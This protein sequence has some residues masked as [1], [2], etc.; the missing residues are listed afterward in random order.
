MDI[1]H[2]GDIAP[3]LAKSGPHPTRILLADDDHLVA[4]GLA[5]AVRSL[6][7]EVVGPA[8]NG[9]MAVSLAR[10]EAGGVGVDLAVLDIRMPV[11][12]GVEAARRLWDEWSIPTVIASAYSDDD[13]ITQARD[14]GGVFGYLLKPI[15]AESLR[16]AISV[17]WSRSLAE[18]GQAGRIAQLEQNLR[19]RQV[20]ERAKWK[21]V[22]ALGLTEPEAH[23]RLQR[24]A[25]DH[26]R[27]LVEVAQQTIDAEDLSFLTNTAK[28]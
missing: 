9:A 26:R 15:T 2:R 19:N 5:S 18:R 24:A 25:R 17:A 21:L 28:A 4:T 20:V 16:V 11:M 8:P 23:S 1:Q 3:S 27:Q 13:Y 7:Y 12:S 6:G 14:A 22:S 10:T